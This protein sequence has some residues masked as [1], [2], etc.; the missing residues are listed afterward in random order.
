MFRMHQ[1][2]RSWQSPA[3]MA[4]VLIAVLMLP[5]FSLAATYTVTN[6]DDSGPGSLRQAVLDANA[7]PTTPHT[8]EFQ[9][10]LTGTIALTSG[11]IE[12]TSQVTINGPGADHLAVSGNQASRIFYIQGAAANVTIKKLT[13]KDGYPRDEAGGGI[14]VGYGFLTLDHCILSDNVATIGGAIHNHAGRIIVMNST[15]VG[16]TVSYTAYP[17]GAGIYNY[18]GSVRI[19][20][21]TIMDNEAVWNGSSHGGGGIF[22]HNGALDIVNSTL[23]GNSAGSGGGIYT[24]FEGGLDSEFPSII[25]IE[26]S[27]LSGNI[28]HSSYWMLGGGGIYI[29]CETTVQVSNS[30]IAGNTAPLG[31]EIRRESWW[32]GQCG[33]LESQGYNLFG[34]NGDSGLYYVSP[35]DT[36]LILQGAIN[37]AIAPLADNGGPTKTHLLVAGSPAI[38]AGNDALLNP[39]ITT[40]Q[41]GTGFPRMVGNQVDIG[42]V[43]GTEGGGQGHCPSDQEQELFNSWNL[44]AC[45]ITDIAIFDLIG[46]AMVNTITVWYNTQFVE[47]GLSFTMEGPVTQSGVFQAKSCDPYQSQWCEGQIA[48]NDVMPSGQYTLIAGVAAICQNSGS[49]GNGFVVVRGCPLDQPSCPEH[50]TLDN[51]TE[52]GAV[53]HTACRT[54]TAGPAYIVTAMGNVTLRAGERITMLPGFQVQTGGRLQVAI[55]PS[56]KP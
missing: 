36:D 21:S 6:L 45:S 8:I 23:S 39:E 31:P 9:S 10:G 53:T 34:Q 51:V 32:G 16:N 55:D 46:D 20:N 1:F 50:L 25:R 19:V 13:I 33:T 22:N 54:I 44:D 4:F 35:V 14:I 28:A 3:C 30:L 38:D 27:T 49:R 11:L 43:E 48:V 2:S 18:I 29:G 5:G 17:N 7:N 24:H 52:N 12:I 47:S 41:R 37:T 42:A 40:D 56:L 15:L 26:N